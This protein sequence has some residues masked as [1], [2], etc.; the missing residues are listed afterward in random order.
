MAG[1]IIPEVGSIISGIG[2]ALE[3]KN[4]REIKAKLQRISSLIHDD[5]K[6]LIAKYIASKLTI[7]R[8][9]YLTHLTLEEIK[10]NVNSFDKLKLLFD[11]DTH[12]KLKA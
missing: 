12:Y 4:E 6:N 10:R 7:K 9:T 1:E 5:H 2:S 11:S 3:W 8:R